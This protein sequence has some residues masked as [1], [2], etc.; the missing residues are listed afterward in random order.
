MGPVLRLRSAV[1]FRNHPV[2]GVSRSAAAKR[3]KN[4]RA[5]L[6]VPRAAAAVATYGVNLSTD[7]VADLAAAAGIPE[8]QQ[9]DR[10]RIA[11]D[12]SNAATALILELRA[13]NASPPGECAQWAR[14]MSSRAGALAAGFG[15]H[16][17]WAQQIKH[18][19]L[20]MRTPLMLAGQETWSAR[21]LEN[22]LS[23]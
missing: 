4:R 22:F 6:S 2:T 16:E 12:L 18:A 19:T 14:K 17:P 3:A 20:L 8:R 7:D 5:R 11:G 9:S 1:G 23:G 15:L 13:F 10:S 21:E